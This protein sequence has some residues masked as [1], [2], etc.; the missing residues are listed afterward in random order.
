MREFIYG[1]ELARNQYPSKF[2]IYYVP[3]AALYAGVLWASYRS[4]AKGTVEWKGREVPVT[5]RGAP[6]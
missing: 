2:I 4:Y 5:L 3:A 6:R 1:T